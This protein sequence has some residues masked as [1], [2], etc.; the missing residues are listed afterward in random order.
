MTKSVNFNSEI[1][2]KKYIPNSKKVW[3][4]KLSAEFL[5]TIFLTWMIGLLGISFGGTK[6]EVLLSGG[7]EPSRLAIGFWLWLDIF[8][9]LAI[10]AR[11]SC[12]LNP[13]VSTYRM[14]I[15]EDSLKYGLIKIGVQMLGGLA[16]GMVIV[17]T[18]QMAHAI[19]GNPLDAIRNSNSSWA[20]FTNQGKAIFGYIKKGTAGHHAIA[21]LGEAM[22]G[23]ILVWSI[24]NKSIKNPVIKDMII[25]LAVGVGVAAMLDFE[26]VVWNPARLLATQ[27]IYDIF[28]GGHHAMSMVPTYAFGEFAGIFIFFGMQ[29]F[30]EKYGIELWE[31]WM[32]FGKVNEPSLPAKKSP[33]KKEKKQIK[34]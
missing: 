24:F 3:G 17:A 29:I 12:D 5:G 22:G 15:K 14:L 28:K 4:V 32:S 27:Y 21:F 31:K 34:H 1:E 23:L 13:L 26:T 2:E 25:A 18:Q 6:F 19:S 20:S 10:F 8:L 30:M 16:A 11:W 9:C 7:H 33:V